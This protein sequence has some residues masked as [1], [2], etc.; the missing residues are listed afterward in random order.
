MLS[1][2]IEVFIG[3][4]NKQ[5]KNATKVALSHSLQWLLY[6][7]LLFVNL[8]A[9]TSPRLFYYRFGILWIILS[10]VVWLMVTGI[11]VIP[12]KLRGLSIAY[13]AA[14]YVIA[15]SYTHLTLPTIYSV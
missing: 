11:K 5:F 2:E 1:R 10:A 12:V 4:W 13:I 8:L 14:P 6:A 15:V 9:L 3:D 7:I